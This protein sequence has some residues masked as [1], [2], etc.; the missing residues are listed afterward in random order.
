MLE[1]K[2]ICK[3]YHTGGLI[4]KALDDVS[5]NLRENE[6][7]AI[8]G[9]SGSGKTTLLNIIGGLDH[10]D[11]GDLIIN[12][13][14][15]KRYK[16]KDWDSYRNHTIGFV[17]QS[18]NLI[19][20]QTILANVELALTISGIGKKERH[21]RAL[22][23]LAKVGLKEQSH[24]KPNQLSGGQMQ[25]VAIARAL[26]NDPDILLA[27]EPT[28]ALDTVT[29]LQVMDLLKEVAK[30]RLVVMVTHNPELAD[31]YATRIVK[32]QDGH[33]IA[34]SDPYMIQNKDDSQHRNF[35]RSSMSFLTSLSLSFNNLK[36]KK[37]RT[38]LTAFAG[39]IGI[40]GIALIMSLSNGVNNYIKS[41]EEETLSEYPLTITKTGFNFAA[42]MT[43]M[44][45]ESQ[46]EASENEIVVSDMLTD[47]FA[48]VGSND[49]K[50]L[51]KHID[52]NLSKV[53][54]EVRAIDYLYDVDPIIYKKNG[55]DY[56]QVNPDST[57]ASIGFGSS[58]SSNSMMSTMMSTD[59]F[60]ELPEEEALYQDSYE[61]LAGRY[62]SSYDE[63][64]LV[65]G[66]HGQISDFVLYTLG[67]R[68][69]D[70]LKAMVESFSRS[71]TVEVPEYDDHYT[72][73]EMI[74]IDFKLVD[75]SSMYQYD[76]EFNI[77]V[78]KS[79]DQ[80]YMLNLL[81]NSDDL[82]IVGVVRPKESASAAMLQMGIAYTKDLTYHLIAL[83]ENSELVQ[84]QLADPEINVLTGKPFGEKE[85]GTLD[86]SRMISIDENR[87]MSSFKIDQHYLQQVFRIDP[88]EITI[89]YDLLPSL[90]Y[91]ELIKD[92]D[93]NYDQE[94]LTTLYKTVSDDFAAYLQ[95]NDLD[96]PARVEE[97]FQDYLNSERGQ[98]V[99]K[100][101][102]GVFLSACG[103]DEDVM[104]LL[105]ERIFALVSDN[106]SLIVQDLISQIQA[107]LMTAVNKLPDAVSFDPAVFASAI[108]LNIDEKEISA[109]IM[110]MMQKETITKDTVLKS[111]GYADLDD[112]SAIYIYPQDFESKSEIIRF[113]DDYNKQM[114]TEDPMKVVSFTD[115]VGTLM[116]SVTDIINIISYILIAFVAISLIVSSIMIGIITYISV[117]ERRK[118]IGILRAIGASKNNIAE[119][120]NAET[121]IIGFL[122]GSMGIII[123]LLLLIPINALIHII[124]DNEEVNAVLPV[125]GA[126]VLVALSVFLTFIGGLIP[127]KK[128]AKSDPVSAL[129]SE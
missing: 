61:V 15:T 49:L 70:E 90:S 51:K 30:D 111:L 79:E 81:D 101:A 91:E 78:D 47:M 75:P 88:A 9:P 34:D 86:F 41:V 24:K 116:A 108:S 27:D 122:S 18:Y 113:L 54:G 89:D 55:D 98:S 48:N 67:L 73:E 57:F 82:K 29:S 127:A 120:F 100:E 69:Q 128:A 105:Q 77:Y 10:Y 14:S 66:S 17:F 40:I 76:N 118:E 72:F 32:L 13:V 106:L 7:V 129:R 21:L 63:C 58:Q 85:A 3:E 42:M 121:M 94:A 123:T 59:V 20:H 99:T 5:L 38:I 56:Y 93:L 62:P 19:P 107:K 4:Q 36:T 103:I 28:G 95:E 126:V 104:N 16:D 43:D 46:R 26:V 8:L 102:V 96:D 6:F 11:S 35:G 119:V 125:A 50:S 25:R 92:I 1:I 68:D 109:I 74:G 97:Y 37:A 110:A 39:S 31:R 71:E 33:I 12:H 115:Y 53:E 114:E 23:A 64:L 65:L 83:A 84:K 44:I 60:F 87:M 45:G 117:L 52:N 22:E 112:P 2:N 124:G 80:A